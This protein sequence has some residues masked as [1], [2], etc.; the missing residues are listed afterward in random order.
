MIQLMLS[1]VSFINWNFIAMD[2][3]L[4]LMPSLITLAHVIFF[5]SDLFLSILFLLV[6]I[7]HCVLWVLSRTLSS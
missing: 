6:I 7:L 5:S 1:H 2:F 3:Y 4:L